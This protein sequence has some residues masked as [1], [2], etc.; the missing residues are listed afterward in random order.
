MARPAQRTS[1]DPSLWY[2]TMRP[3]SQSFLLEKYHLIQALFSCFF[4]GKED[5]LFSV[6]WPLPG[7]MAR[8]SVSLV[9]LL[10]AQLFIAGQGA[11][12]ANKPMGPK[13]GVDLGWSRIM[14]KWRYRYMKW[15]FLFLLLKPLF[16]PCTRKCVKE[17]KNAWPFG[18]K[19]L[20]PLKHLLAMMLY[21]PRHDTLPIS[22]GALPILSLNLLELTTTSELSTS[23]SS[24]F[25][26]TS[27]HSYCILPNLSHG[28]CFNIKKIYELSIACSLLASACKAVIWRWRLR[29]VFCVE[30]GIIHA[31]GFRVVCRVR[32]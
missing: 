4:H 10:L 24:P 19:I 3:A 9:T 21:Q 28:T 5:E 1:S 15:P 12:Y 29:L 23:S 25:D 17:K 20:P 32:G 16:T 14:L 26:C 18:V 13:S 30:S 22:P 2:I 7:S 11:T 8:K 6:Q 31:W 27:D